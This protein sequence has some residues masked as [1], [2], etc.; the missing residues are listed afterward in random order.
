MG[1]T[2]ELLG[3]DIRKHG[4]ETIQRIFDDYAKYFEPYKGDELILGMARR[5]QY[6]RAWA[7]F[8]NEYPLVLTPFLPHPTYALGRDAEGPEGVIEVLGAGIYSFSMNYMGLPAGIV[9]TNENDGLP[10]GVQI[11]GRRFREDL[12]IDALEAIEQRIGIMA[13]IL[14]ARESVTRT[15]SLGMP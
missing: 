7:V 3:E 10:V 2:I 13:D 14:F 4:S 11:V 8:L 1:E 15:G 5:A 12:I 9:S 6:A